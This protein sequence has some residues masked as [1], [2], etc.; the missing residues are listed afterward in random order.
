MSLISAN[1]K[2]PKS[3]NRYSAK[4][5][6]EI[7]PIANSKLGNQ[8]KTLWSVNTSALVVQNEPFCSD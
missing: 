1:S 6:H 2:Q 8:K 4:S 5:K 3:T 7:K